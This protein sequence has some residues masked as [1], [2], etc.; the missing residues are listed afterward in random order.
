MQART[1]NG[2]YACG[3]PGFKSDPEHVLM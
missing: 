1:P 2:Y 3:Y